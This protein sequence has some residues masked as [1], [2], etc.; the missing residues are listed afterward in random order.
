MDTANSP[1]ASREEEDD[2]VA[3]VARELWRFRAECRREERVF[4][5]IQ[6]MN[7]P[8]AEIRAEETHGYA[9]TKAACRAEDDLAE[10][11]FMLRRPL[12]AN[13]EHR[14]SA[15]L[16]GDRLVVAIAGLGDHI[17]SEGEV[18]I[19]PLEATAIGRPQAGSIPEDP[20][21]NRSEPAYTMPGRPELPG[22]V[23]P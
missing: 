17:P 22:R 3:R 4:R 2:R 13:H 14:A 23:H 16:V 20:G 21:V 19:I 7:D 10:A 15:V 5:K 1:R 6:G 11:V 18:L 8:R 9:A 12:K